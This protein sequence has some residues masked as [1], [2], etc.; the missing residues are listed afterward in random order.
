VAAE[1]VE[2]PRHSHANDGSREEDEKCHFVAQGNVLQIPVHGRFFRNFIVAIVVVA[3]A[4]KVINGK[5]HEE[6]RP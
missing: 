5:V 4:P 2:E 1:G 3:S 6:Q